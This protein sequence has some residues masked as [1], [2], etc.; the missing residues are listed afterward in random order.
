MLDIEQIR[1]AAQQVGLD[2]IGI[3]PATYLAEDAVFMDEW[4]ERLMGGEADGQRGGK[5]KLWYLAN[6]RDKR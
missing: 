4:V 5:D 2:D 6:N 3:V 1:T